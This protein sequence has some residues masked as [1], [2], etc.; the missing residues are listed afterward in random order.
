MLLSR[1]SNRG[2]SV[3]NGT[4]FPRPQ[5]IV[6]GMRHFFLRAVGNNVSNGTLFGTVIRETKGEEERRRLI[7]ER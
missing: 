2:N 6:S 3:W 5:E 4:L 7:R 1:S